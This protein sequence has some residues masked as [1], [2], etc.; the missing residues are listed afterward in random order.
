MLRVVKICVHIFA[1]IFDTII[2]NVVR[3]SDADDFFETSYAA[4]FIFSA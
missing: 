2:R 4:T 1:Y 3:V